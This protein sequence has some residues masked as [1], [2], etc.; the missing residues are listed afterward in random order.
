MGQRLARASAGI[1]LLLALGS[2]AGAQPVASD[3]APVAAPLTADPPPA[4]APPAPVRAPVQRFAIDR[5]ERAWSE[6]SSGPLERARRTR[7]VADEIG[8]ASLDPLAR[9]LLWDAAATDSLLDRAQAA[10][11]LA[12]ELPLAQAALAQA[13]WRSGA[14]LAAVRSASRA[15]AALTTQLDGWLWLGATGSLLAALALAAGAGIFLALRGFAAARFV[16]HDLGDVIEP[17]MPG[18]A[19]AA[20]LAGLVLVPVALGEGLAG[21]ALG[22]V[23][24]GFVARSRSQ[25]V[26]VGCAALCLVA[27]IHPLARAAGH[28][29]AAI[30]ADP[31][32]VASAAADTGLLDTTDSLRLRRAAGSFAPASTVEP[33]PIALMALAEWKRRSGDLAAADAQYAPLVAADDADADLLSNAAAVKLA[34]GDP[35]AAIDLYRRAIEIAPS[36]LLWFNLSQAHGAAIDV[37]QHDR[38]LAAAQS[39]DPVAVSELTKRLAGAHSPFAASV[40]PSRDRV[41]ERLLATPV[42]PAALPFRARLAPG[43]LGRSLPLAVL[44][45][46][47]AAGLGVLLG[48]RIEPSAGCRDCGAHLCPRCGAAPRGDGRCE[49]CQRRRFEGRG[50]WDRKSA[51][52]SVAERARGAALWLFPGLLD[53]G[54]STLGLPIAIAASAAVVFAFR[55]A[56]VLPDAGSVG[57]A[58]ALAF[59][60]AT[61]ACVALHLLLAAISGAV[62]S[63]SRS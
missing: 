44:A 62:A 2:A 63:R 35:N 37:E 57:A 34:L 14:P 27:A 19:R 43:W 47:L 16:A 41:R 3:A 56:A 46:A 9:A 29:I 36:A 20:L 42:D 7:A 13:E 25:R 22:L 28:R 32:L 48:S 12:P 10:V 23:T 15:I 51:S 31:A 45:F 30:G 54:G 49:A 18:F 60:V 58:G 6:P 5:L 17:S 61:A 52:R 53:R 21:L 55:H 8:I 38:A 50:A 1:A 39:L 11:L 40:P 4:A 33:D 24:L 59:G 26:A